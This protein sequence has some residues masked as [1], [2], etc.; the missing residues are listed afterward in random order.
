[1]IKYYTRCLVCAGFKTIEHDGI[2]HAGYMAFM[3]LLSIFPFVVFVLASSS[4]LGAS[5]LVKS[6][7]TDIVSTLPSNI[8]DTL[9]PRIFEILEIPPQS[10][11][12]LAIFGTLW[13]LSSF[14]EGIR[15]ILNRVHQVTSP[16]PFWLRRLLSVAQFLITSMVLFLTLVAFVFIPLMLRK[17]PQIIA[18]IN[19]VSPIWILF[20]YSLI[21][22]MLFLTVSTIYYFIPNTKLKFKQVIPGAVITVILWLFSGT[23]LSKCTAYYY[24][25]LNLIYGSLGSIIV[26]L[27]FFH[28]ISLIFIYGAE[29]NQQLL[30]SQ[31]TCC[32]QA[33]D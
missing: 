24:G 30:D 22:L 29:F 32:Q 20:R 7:I 25:Q 5:D 2:E 14:V 27:L 4:F 8:I 18:F 12:T 3:V 1:M 28:L 26:T 21:I 6:G 31:N 9:I 16:P 23:L 17:I 11:L 19:T 15:T 13:T 33:A 10:L